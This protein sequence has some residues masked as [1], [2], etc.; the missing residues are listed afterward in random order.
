MRSPFPGVDPYLEHPAYWPDFHAGF[1]TYARDNMLD[2]LPETYDAR[3]EESV[4]LVTVE[5]ERAVG[6]RGDVTITRDMTLPRPSSGAPGTVTL[7]PIVAVLPKPVVEEVREIRI[8]ILRLPEREVVTVIELLSPANKAGTG[9]QEYLLKRAELSAHQV[10]LVEL[11]LLVGGQRV[12]TPEPLPPGD[13]FAIVSRWMPKPICEMYGWSI[14]H[15]LPR[16]RVPL[17]HPDPDILFD[18]G[19]VFE[20]T[21]ERGRYQR[22]IS[23]SKPP[24][25]PLSGDDMKWATQ[26][27]ASQR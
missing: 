14:R 24:H 3:I 9:R 17:K 15:P 13:C 23:Y 21:Y 25:A 22:M 1:I 19:A 7:E 11:D 2:A 16:I 26:L 18:L 10:N 8:Q 4:R 5:S 6:A 20:T 27:A 12:P